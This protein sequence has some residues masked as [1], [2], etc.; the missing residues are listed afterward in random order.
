M[1]KSGFY[2][3]YDIKDHNGRILRKGR[4]RANSFVGNLIALLWSIMVSKG[5]SNSTTYLL[6]SRADLID[7]SGNARTL[8]ISNSA[9]APAGTHTYG[10][11]VGTGTTPVAIGQV[12]LASPIVHG[13][14]S[15]Q[16]QYG[17]TTVETLIK[18]PTEW[19]Y[20]IIRA[21]SNSSGATITVNEAGLF[22]N[23]ST[24]GG[25]DFQYMIAR[26]L[27]PGLEIPNGATLTLRYIISYSI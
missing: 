15:G 21:F 23:A 4:R 1:G 2:L 12:N 13:T 14:G 26:D 25:L 7:T 27:I 11:R 6:V 16:L 19:F 3:E 18:S 10:I 17:I 8:T 24:G 20:R 22:Y 5:T 9:R